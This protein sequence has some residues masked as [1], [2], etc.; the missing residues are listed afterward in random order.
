M[1]KKEIIEEYI[2]SC[3]EMVEAATKSIKRDNLDPHLQSYPSLVQENTL[4]P[5]LYFHSE[6]LSPPAF[7][8]S[9]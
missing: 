6:M 4:Q 8:S 3:T 5:E 7:I 1:T 9:T 2:H